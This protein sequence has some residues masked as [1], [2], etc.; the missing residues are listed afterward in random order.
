[1]CQSTKGF[2]SFAAQVC[3]FPE[4]RVKVDAENRTLVFRHGDDTEAVELTQNVF[5]VRQDG[6]ALVY[7]MA[8]DGRVYVKSDGD[9]KVVCQDGAEFLRVKTREFLRVELVRAKNG[10]AK[11]KPE[12]VRVPEPSDEPT[13]AAQALFRAMNGLHTVEELAAMTGAEIRALA[14]RYDKKGSGKGRTIPVLLNEILEH[15]AVL[16]DELLTQAAM[17]A[18]EVDETDN[19]DE[20]EADSAQPVDVATSPFCPGCGQDVGNVDEEGCCRYC[21]AQIFS[22]EGSG[23]DAEAEVE[24]AQSDADGET[25]EAVVSNADAEVEPDSIE[26]NQGDGQMAEIRTITIAELAK[27][28]GKEE[29]EIRIPNRDPF[30]GLNWKPEDLP[31]IVT[32]LKPES[33]KG[34]QVLVSGVGPQWL[35]VAVVHA[36]HPCQISLADPKVAAGQ[37]AI[38]DR[39]KPGEVAG[40]LTFTVTEVGSAVKVE[41]TSETPI[42]AENLGLLVPP[43]VP[44]GK[45]VVLSGRTATWAVVQIATAYQHEVPAV[46]GFQ[47]GTGFVC[48]ITHNPIYE[49]GATFA[50]IEEIPAQAQ[51]QAEAVA[52]PTQLTKEQLD[53]KMTEWFAGWKPVAMRAEVDIYPPGMAN[54]LFDRFMMNALKLGMLEL[55]SAPE[56]DFEIV[57][58]VEEGRTAIVA[59]IQDALIGK[60]QEVWFTFPLGMG[61]KPSEVDEAEKV[62]VGQG[63]PVQWDWNKSALIATPPYPTWWAE[64]KKV[65]E[66]GDEAEAESEETE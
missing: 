1:M 57:Q 23:D 39:L 47:P 46:F 66:E 64:Y 29:E 60:D 13:P 65:R 41:Y 44:T 51:A 12:T 33:E 7:A 50:S 40:E 55:K 49:I 21:G 15:E 14:V 16:E 42:A 8:A 61:G 54:G 45:P 5:I 25:P 31:A 48:A 62:L 32:V 43:T 22:E 17:K 52:K 30:M 35:I 10:K 34:G 26:V 38:N 27:M 56:V 3:P 59:A 18:L 2:K 36:L 24:D 11:A 28:I 20:A 9:F 4:M 19:S 53:E 37:V 58:I 6:K 63:Y